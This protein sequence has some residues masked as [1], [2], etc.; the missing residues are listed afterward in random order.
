[1]ND[2]MQTLRSKEDLSTLIAGG[3]QFSAA[4][5]QIASFLIRD[6]RRVCFMSAAEVAQASG[7]SQATVTRFANQLG[8]AGFQELVA[9]VQ[10]IVRSELTGLG[11]VQ[12]VRR[13]ND[14]PHALE[15]IVDEEIANLRALR[16]PAIVAAVERLAQAIIEA[17]RVYVAGMR[18]ASGIARQ[19]AFFLRKLHPSVVHL[20]QLSS[21][22][23]ELLALST[24]PN[25]LLLGLVY[26]RYPREMIALMERAR[27]RGIR[28][29]VVTD[30]L[31][32]PGMALAEFSL[33]APASSAGVFDSYCSFQVLA[34][35]LFSAMASRETAADSYLERFE[36][37]AREANVFIPFEIR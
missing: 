18:S 19:M 34:S 22:T 25:S 37:F 33:I 6:Y 7:V 24:P 16:T 10:G 23:E 8:F 9:A 3:I 31:H 17:P 30:S 29:S 11:R 20:Q 27:A 32:S 2:S 28:I 26:P 35:F 12:E 14:V 36:T 4:H 13:D 21:E 15:R 1:M 5:R